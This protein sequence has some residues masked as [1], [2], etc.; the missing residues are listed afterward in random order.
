MT[1]EKIRLFKFLNFF[2]IGGTERQFV[3][4]VKRLDPS[5]F[6]VQIGCFQKIGPFLADV[7]AGG[8]PVTAFQIKSMCSY[9]TLRRQLQFARFLRQSRIQVLHTYGWWANVFG[10]PAAKLARVPVTIASIRDMGAHLSATQCRIQR[11]VCRLADCVLVNSDSVR[12]WLLMQRYS[13]KKIRVIRNGIE[14]PSLEHA[15][16]PVNVREEYGVPPEA[17]LIATVCRL[18]HVKAVND[19]LDAAALVIKEHPAAR[20]MIIGDGPERQALMEQAQ[21]SSIADRVIFTGFRS[22]TAQILPQLTMSVLSSLTEGLSN[23]L[24]ES[25]G[26][27][28]PVVATRVGGN[29]EIV[30][31]G[32][33]GLLV[34]PR[35]PV[36]LKQAICRVLEDPVLAARMGNAGRQRILRQFSV[37]NTVRETETLYLNLLQQ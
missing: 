31:E 14:E 33:T 20:F 26:A 21:R 35:D 3:N 29:T 32:I 12:D 24:L 18:N 1:S 22:D 13:S 8:R 23:T 6:D 16:T 25:M 37:E 34:P 36:S 30:A 4:L 11:A 27:G 2:C 19:L 7:E 17:P 15:E 28:V 5:R 10:I 9:E